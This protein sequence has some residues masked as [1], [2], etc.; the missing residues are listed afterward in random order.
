MTSWRDRA[1]AIR[2]GLQ[3]ALSS[4][5]RDTP[6][7]TAP[8]ESTPSTAEAR[9]NSGT[10]APTT[11]A[12]T[13]VDAAA[14]DVTAA[15]PTEPVDSSAE[16]AAALSTPP[17]S[18][19]AVPAPFRMRGYRPDGKRERFGPQIDSS[20]AGLARSAKVSGDNAL[21]NSYL[22]RLRAISPNDPGIARAEKVSTEIGRAH[23]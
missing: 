14:A 11:G 22:E 20:L 21:S 15:G 19:P 13:L 18:P 9:E 17:D 6:T 7:A 12:S 3:S 5:G 4:L 10:D 23:V 2:E 16:I 1:G 8:T